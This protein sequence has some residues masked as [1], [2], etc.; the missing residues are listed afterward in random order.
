MNREWGLRM[1]ERSVHSRL[2]HAARSTSPASTDP[3][4][5]RAAHPAHGRRRRRPGAGCPAETRARILH[6]AGDVLAAFRGRLI[7]V[8]ASETGKTIAEADVEVSEAIDFAHYYAERA[9]R[10]RPRCDGAVCG[11][12]RG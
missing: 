5:S 10:A 6:D 3:A 4:R 11:A 2:G 7:E 12:V 9:L 8:M 1:L